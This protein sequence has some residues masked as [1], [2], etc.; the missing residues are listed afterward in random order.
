MIYIT[1]HS[2]IAHTV[3]ARGIR[4]ISK[5]GDT[6]CVDFVTETGKDDWWAIGLD[7]DETTDGLPDSIKVDNETYIGHDGIERLRLKLRAK[8]QQLELIDALE[9]L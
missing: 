8:K 9:E 7:A 6:F 1:Y 3:K 2:G 4:S 5:R